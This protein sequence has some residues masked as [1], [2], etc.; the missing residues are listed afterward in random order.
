MCP[1][2]S[3]PRHTHTHTRT[4]THTHTHT[5]VIVSVL[6]EVKWPVITAEARWFVS[7]SCNK[8]HIVTEQSVLNSELLIY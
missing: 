5:V 7:Y 4:H 8:F 1:T 2:L 3:P 6:R